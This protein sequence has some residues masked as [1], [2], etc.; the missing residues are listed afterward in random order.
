MQR[1]IE[2]PYITVFSNDPLIY[3]KDFLSMKKILKLILLDIHIHPCYLINLYISN[4]TPDFYKI[5]KAI[6]P[7]KQLNEGDEY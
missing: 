6:Y 5:L 7:N 4:P 2:Y 1:V 3:N